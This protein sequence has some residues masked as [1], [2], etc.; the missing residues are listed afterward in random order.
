MKRRLILLT[1]ATLL[2]HNPL[3]AQT[4]KLWYTQPSKK[5][6]DAL[7]IGNGRIGGMI[8]GTADTER[9]QY[10]EQTLWTGKPRDYQR[11]G[12]Y[13]YLP[14]MRQLLFDGKQKE[15]EAMGEAHFMGRKM[16]EED[17]DKQKA[18]WFKTISAVKAPGAIAYNDSKW[19]NINLPTEKGWEVIP[20]FEGLDGAVWFRKTFELPADWVGKDLILS[21]GRMRDMDFTLVNGEQV[22]S[23]DGADYRRYTIPAKLLHA[24]KNQIAIQVINYW[25]KGGLTSNARELAIYPV[26]YDHSEV[27]GSKVTDDIAIDPKT[28]ELVKVIKLNGPWKYWIQDNQPPQLPRYNADYQPFADL[29]L[30]MAKTG[31]ITNYKRDLDISNATAHVTY[32]AGGVNYTRE[33]IA[34]NPDQVMAVHLT[35]DKPGKISFKALLQTLH[36]S[37][38][39][40]KVDAHTLSLSFKVRNGA[41]RGV[42]Y[43]YADAKGGK[44]TVT[45]EGISISGANEATLY[46]TAATNFKTYKDVSGNPETICAKQIAAVRTKTY[47]AVKA[48]HVADYKKLFNTF[49]VTFGTGSNDALPTD[50]RILKYNS[51]T[52]PGLVSLFVQ[53]SR[54]LLISSSRPGSKVPA[55]LQG[56]WNDLLTPPWGSKFTTNINLQ[57]NYWGAEMLNLSGLTQPLFSM[58]DDLRQTGAATAKAHYNAP[59]WVLHHNTDLWRGAAPV[60]ASNHGIWVTG[61]AWIS[62]SLWEHYQFIQDKAFLQTRA[63]PTMKGA[64]EFFV[65]NLVKDPV[66]GYLI[67]TPSNSPEHGG[68][69]AGPTMDHQIIRELFKNTIAAAKILGVDAEFSK[70]LQEKY[71]QIAPNQIGKYGQLQEWMQDKDDTTDTHRHVSHMWGVHP[72]T[73]ITA[74]TPDL[75]NAAKKSMYYRGD[76]GTGWSIAWKINIWARMRDGDHSYLMLTKLLS[77]A[78]AV[79]NHEKGGVYHNLFDAHPPFQIDGNFGGAAGIGEMILQSQFGT[80]DILPALP[81]ALPNGEVKGIKARGG[82]VLN[83]KWQNGALQQV[84]ITSEAGKPCVVN[85]QDKQVKFDTEK[86]KSYKLNGDLKKI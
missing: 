45:N 21:L 56:L 12:A 61:A 25:D 33:Y 70:T 77:P 86:G 30:Q 83:I 13:Q 85:Y 18:V 5:W 11:E 84:E 74:A 34:S 31:T 54:Y 59:G 80:L 69:V 71:S 6:T 63:Y 72:G 2:C 38:S 82:F 49:T 37:V 46:L 44:L 20:G 47:A 43:L 1:I 19:K 64:A 60:N 9:L 65:A 57:M 35:A 76:D 51:N 26:G 78:D 42:S 62:E 39:I 4:L 8:Y 75:L 23:V 55:N 52:D 10:N 48:A 14:Q 50:E 16:N 67:S 7:P 79:P 81:K 66:T 29:F 27:K 32:T 40:R 28:G 3:S 58:V 53:Y 68:L 22:G 17:Y 41:L 24:G 36:Q 15:A 73:E